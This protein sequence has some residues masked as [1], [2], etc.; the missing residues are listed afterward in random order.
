MSKHIVIYGSGVAGA[1]LASRL[2]SLCHV[3]LV[4]PVDYFEVPMAMPRAV[5]EADIADT[6]V[7]P[8]ADFLPK[9]TIIQ[10][11]LIELDGNR[12]VVE[13]MDG[14]RLVLDGDIAVLATGSRYASSLTRAQFG[15]AAA[16]REQFKSAEDVV[17]ASQKIVIVGSGAVGVELAGEIA[18]SFP[19]RDVTVIESGDRLLKG[20]SLKVADHARRTLESR[21]VKFLTQTRV[22]SPELPANE[23]IQND[24]VV[25]TND[26][27]SLPY[28]A[29]FWCI[30]GTPN[31][32]YMTP[33]MADRLDEYGRIQVEPDLRVTGE[34][35]L[36]ALGD[37]AN[38]DEA[39]KALY[40][41]NHVPVVEQNIRKLL[42]NP[43]ARLKHYKAKTDDDMMLVTLGKR[44]G[45]AH[46][47]GLGMVK[48]N[49]FT[50]MAKAA[51]M[52]VPMY[53]KQLGLKG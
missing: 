29:L 15:S 1:Q 48:A 31:T 20:T 14:E 24:G 22:I 52:L 13:T 12:G 39:K 2:Q 46:L 34:A 7:I 42:K 49:W 11:R 25:Q 17:R 5:V 35:A 26:G 18:E 19:G 3:T 4:S 44:G 45:V 33:N 47:P 28:D 8:L 9:A 51:T 10:G 40:V 27:Q 30:G 37:I 16:R 41:R 50:R 38:L 6:S 43:D 21:G 36:F 53:R 32:A 23:Q